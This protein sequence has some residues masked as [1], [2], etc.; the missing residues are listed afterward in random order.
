[1]TCPSGDQH[2]QP[3][4]Q[5]QDRSQH[6]ESSDERNRLPA[7]FG[8]SRPNVPRLPPGLPHLH[9]GGRQASSAIV[10]FSW[11]AA[12]REGTARQRRL[13]RSAPG[14]LAL[15]GNYG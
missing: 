12:R 13:W 4:S 9:M 14:L 8:S 10:D 3:T 7:G 1:V 15:H 2:G 6:T 11:E 5:R